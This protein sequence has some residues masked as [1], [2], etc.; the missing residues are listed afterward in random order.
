M[1]P[2][3]LAEEERA[4][5]D[6]RRVTRGGLGPREARFPS[7]GWQQA[8]VA[9]VVVEAP[10]AVTLRLRLEHPTHFLPGQYYNVRLAA[11]GRPRPVQRAYSVGSSPFPDPSVIDL[12]VKEVAG[13]LVS[14]RLVNDVAPGD[15]LEVRG[16]AG[17][18]HWSEGD[19]G[20]LLL[21]GAGSG[22]VPLMAVVRYGWT[23]GLEVPMTLLCSAAS[24]DHALYHDDLAHLEKACPWLSVLHSF[25]RDPRD[26]RAAY[27]RRIDPA[28][29]GDACEGRLPHLAYLCGPPAM[30]EDVAGWLADLGL[31]PARVRTEK[32]D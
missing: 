13:G 2:Q 4:R 25:T 21:V 32:Y 28:M 20:P 22:V 7:R 26:R 6:A 12:G 14:P 3:P 27:H 16:P 5:T 29:L 24:F 15:K 8:L 9:E 23:R 30:V 31:D 11:P 10:D 18:F 1:K 19:G 17:R